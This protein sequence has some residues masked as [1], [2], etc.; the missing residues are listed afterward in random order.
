MSSE[1]TN[2][3]FQD[4]M[5]LGQISI[6]KL[7]VWKRKPWNLWDPCCNNPFL[8]ITTCTTI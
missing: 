7:S 2:N 1:V 4:M 3:Y 5:L 8:N 6:D